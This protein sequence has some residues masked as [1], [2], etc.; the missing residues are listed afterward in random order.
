MAIERSSKVKTSDK[1]RVGNLNGD[2][3]ILTIPKDKQGL[4]IK[5]EGTAASAT[6]NIGFNDFGNIDGYENSTIAVGEQLSI[7]AGADDEV[8]AIIAASTSSTELR[9]LANTW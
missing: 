9:I 1:F 6:V 2:Y 7:Y 4:T 8:Y 5:V 3:H